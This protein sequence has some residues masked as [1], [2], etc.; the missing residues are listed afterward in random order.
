MAELSCEKLFVHFQDLRSGFQQGNAESGN[1]DEA[2]WW[3]GEPS[4][5]ITR[6]SPELFFH[7]LLEAISQTEKLRVSESEWLS[8]DDFRM[9]MDTLFAAFRARGGEIEFSGKA[10]S[11]HVT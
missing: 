5:S 3:E 6:A 10:E 4:L 11:G 8:D 9:H 1:P 7:S 2:D